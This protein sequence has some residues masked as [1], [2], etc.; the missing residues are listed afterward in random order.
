MFRHFLATTLKKTF[1]RTLSYPIDCTKELFE[2]YS[3]LEFILKNS[4]HGEAGLKLKLKSAKFCSWLRIFWDTS[5]SLLV[6]VNDNC[7]LDC[8][9]RLFLIVLIALPVLFSRTRT[10]HSGV[11]KMPRVSNSYGVLEVKCKRKWFWGLFLLLFIQTWTA[12]TA[13]LPLGKIQKLL[14]GWVTLE[15]ELKYD[16]SNVFGQSPLLPCILHNSRMNWLNSPV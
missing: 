6:F 8:L 15:S 3:C 9:S 11:L 10:S 5:L 4:K 7:C 14:G 13:S 2:R 16:F 1:W 12:R